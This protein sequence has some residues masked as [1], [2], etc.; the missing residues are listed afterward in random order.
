MSKVVKQF[1]RTVVTDRDPDAL[2][3]RRVQQDF[4][5]VESLTRQDQLP[6][7]SVRNLLKQGVVPPDP[8]QLS[9][10]DLTNAPQ[11]LREAFEAV[12]VAS[13]SFMDLDARLRERFNNDPLML[14]DFLADA[15]NRDEAVEL[16]LISAP[17]PG[18]EQPKSK[19][20]SKPESKPE[21]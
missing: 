8:D 13:A 20:D 14:A 5:G 21:S 19:P 1:V 2:S 7:T 4:S 18:A 11:S 9:F 10:A 17:D 12:E 3:P 15:D 6:L 16:G